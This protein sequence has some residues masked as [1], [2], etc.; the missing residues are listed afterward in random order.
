M[1]KHKLISKFH[2]QE[3][4]L[5]NSK[6]K[7]LSKRSEGRSKTTIKLKNIVNKVK[8]FETLYLTKNLFK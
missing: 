4:I 1:N 6:K 2:Y 5:L 3:M 8:I 7:K